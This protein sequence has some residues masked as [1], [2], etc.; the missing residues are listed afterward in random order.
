MKP[1][2][3]T[4]NIRLDEG[5]SAPLPLDTARAYFSL[6]EDIREAIEF[7]LYSDALYKDDPWRYCYE[8][9]TQEAPPALDRIIRIIHE[10]KIKPSQRIYV[11]IDGSY[12]DHPLPESRIPTNC[13]CS[14][15]V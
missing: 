3:Q 6:R 10:Q 15:T 8:N 14:I 13:G 11:G 5:L 2:Q 12:H 7:L 4:I 9:E 1:T